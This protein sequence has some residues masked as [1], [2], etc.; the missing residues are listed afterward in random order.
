MATAGSLLGKRLPS[1]V[2]KNLHHRTGLRD[3]KIPAF[4]QQRKVVLFGV[5]GAFAPTCHH[6]HA[7]EFFRSVREFQELGADEVACVS[8]NDAF[9]LDA[10]R[11]HLLARETRLAAVGD[12]DDGGVTMLSDGN[13][14]F[15]EAS[16]LQLKME[17]PGM[18]TRLRRFSALID[19]GVW[20]ILNVDS[21]VRMQET[22]AA[23]LLS[24]IAAL[25]AG[26]LE[27]ARGEAAAKERM[28]PAPA[29]QGGRA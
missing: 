29:D 6:D 14:D 27:Q 1:L 2:L 3:V 13:G 15:A 5:Q 20:R 23:T 22:S 11:R 12:D 18:G 21:S 4:F 25:N 16:G 8:V 19:D 24:Q 10:W 7:P 28:E 26:Q 9:V 17:G